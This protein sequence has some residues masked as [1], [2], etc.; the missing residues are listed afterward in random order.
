MNKLLF[1]LPATVFLLTISATAQRASTSQPPP[2]ATT[3]IGRWSLSLETGPAFPVG[4]FHS[5]ASMSPTAGFA[6]TG[7]ST[8]LSVNYRIYHHLGITLAGALQENPS[9][10]TPLFPDEPGLQGQRP[11]T[12]TRK[13]W[14]MVRLLA[15]PSWSIP[16]LPKKGLS[17]R[18]RALAGALKT[19]VPDMAVF[20]P[21]LPN[22]LTTGST[23][24]FSY[25]SLPW[26]F[27]YQADAGLQW[28]V[29]RRLAL[30]LD[31]GYSGSKHE[32]NYKYADYFSDLPPF[33]AVNTAPYQTGRTS[34]TV[35][36]GA[37]YTR[38]GIG[39]GF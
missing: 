24:Y 36:T 8:G 20:T 9:A 3:G 29:T 6:R 26:A 31:A 19:K 28:N 39:I 5:I 38:L 30:T 21:G 25:G 12:V 22:A 34:S 35:A 18:F 1:W 27:A 14:S 4:A 17:L 7:Y 10:T 32:E 33:V 13:D 37:L 11:S 16:L 15:G 2:T 23:D